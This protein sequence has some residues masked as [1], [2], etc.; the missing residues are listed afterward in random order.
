MQTEP[1][2][3]SG[4]RMTAEAEIGTVR[5]RMVKVRAGREIP[6]QVARLSR[7]RVLMTR[8]CK[9]CGRVRT[10]YGTFGIC[11]TLYCLRNDVPFPALNPWGNSPPPDEER[12]ERPKRPA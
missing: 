4:G 9:L 10:V 3:W 7:G 6:Q 1:D 11:R 12:A 5:E 2:L 8:R